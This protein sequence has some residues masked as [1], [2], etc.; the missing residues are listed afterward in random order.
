LKERLEIENGSVRLMRQN[1]EGSWVVELELPV[2]P[3]LD[4]LASELATSESRETI[5]PFGCRWYDRN[6]RAEG[7]ILEEPPTTRRIRFA[8]RG[9]REGDEAPEESFQLAFPY[10]IYAIV[11]QDGD[12]EEMKIF[13]RPSPLLSR[14][15]ELYLSNLYNV[16]LSLGH[17]AHNRACLRP[18]PDVRDLP[19]TRQTEK[20]INHFWNTEFNR[21]IEDNC[22]HHYASKH[23]EMVS[24]SRWEEK[25][26]HDPLFVL[27]FPW[28]KAGISAGDLITGLLG[29]PS[30]GRQPLR[31]TGRLA[32]LCYRLMAEFSD[33]PEFDHRLGAWKK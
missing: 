30:P 28:E 32:D 26:R 12:F 25:S 14:D 11:F 4:R 5:L 13:Y 16:Q 17:R 33:P 7:L 31:S 19:L 21:D 18:K 8:A 27:R 1:P 24:L 2:E 23:Q 9:A 10:I 22:F 20:L 3:Y 15:D 6:R 29:K